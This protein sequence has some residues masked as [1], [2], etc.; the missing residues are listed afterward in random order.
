MNDSDPYINVE[1]VRNKGQITI[2]GPSK[3]Q[4]WVLPFSKSFTLRLNGCRGQSAFNLCTCH[5]IMFLRYDISTHIESALSF[6]C[7][8]FIKGYLLE[9][10]NAPKN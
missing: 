6:N 5:K 7:T 10:K 3:N 1:S 2:G 8:M 4:L 9:A